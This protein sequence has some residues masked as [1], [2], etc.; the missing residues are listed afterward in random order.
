VGGKTGTTNEATDVW[1]VGFTPDITV[2][3]WVG[4]DEKKS[5]GENIYGANLALPIWIDFMGEALKHIPP[6]D[7]A[8]IHRPT[9]QEITLAEREAAAR[10][11]SAG[12]VKTEDIPPPPPPSELSLIG[13]D[14]EDAIDRTEI[15]LNWVFLGRLPAVLLTHE[16]ASGRRKAAFEGFLEKHP[17]V[18]EV[19]FDESVFEQFVGDHPHLKGINFDGLEKIVLILAT[20][21]D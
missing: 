13:E 10:E 12:L 2:G 19:S 20:V 8:N 14:L 15:F 16:F 3:V 5:L 18:K 21:T 1:F 9:E 4:F 7:F 6:T 17:H 11:I